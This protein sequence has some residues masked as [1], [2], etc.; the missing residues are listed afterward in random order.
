MT[1]ASTVGLPRESMIC[2]PMTPAILWALA[3]PGLLALA[4]L[5]AFVLAFLL[6]LVLAL[7]GMSPPGRFATRI[8]ARSRRSYTENTETLSA[9]LGGILRLRIPT[10]IVKTRFPRKQVGTLRSE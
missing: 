1:S 4:A 10:E 2:R 5:P 6:A 9:A 3:L 8:L 7:V